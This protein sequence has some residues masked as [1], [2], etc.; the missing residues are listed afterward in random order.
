MKGQPQRRQLTADAPVGVFDSGVGG[1][2]VLR[3]LLRE[4]PDERYVYFGDTGNCPYGV[5]S[6]AEITQL[7]LNGAAFLLERGVKLIVVACN[8]ASSASIGAL[9]EAY[10]QVKFIAV[11]PAVKPAAEMTRVGRVA[12]AA[13]NSA[14]RSDYLRGLIAQFAQGVEVYPV[15]CQSL[16][17]LAEAGLLDGP[18]VE[19]EIR[20]GIE[21]LLAKGIDV[22]ALGCTHFPAMRPVFERVV[23]PQVRVIDSGAAVARQT[24]RVLRE[25]GLL[26]NPTGGPATASRPLRSDDEFWRSGESVT[27]EQVASRLLGSPV[28]GRYASG[29]LWSPA[30]AV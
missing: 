19:R 16:V 23:G 25:Q 12:I 11:V 17:T 13:T 22:L 3:D 10:P 14:A 8:T 30:D 24:R 15:G 6:Q 9:R 5:R 1:L 2:T 21:P 7:S 4:L 20:R 29:M 27:F 18:E 26:A 28:E